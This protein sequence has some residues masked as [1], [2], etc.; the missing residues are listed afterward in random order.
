MD[1]TDH[2]IS[3]YLAAPVRG[4]PG[5]AVDPKEK[6]DNVQAAVQLGYAIRQAFPSLLLFVPHE[7]EVVID[8]LWHN[9]LPSD[10]I[11]TATSQ[12]AA[13]KDFMIVYDGDGISAGMAREIDV[14]SKAG[15]P[16]VCFDLFNEEAKEEIAMVMQKLKG[17]KDETGRSLQI[18]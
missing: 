15:K 13:A 4:K 6:W 18:D 8:R 10:D 16:I 9:G 12:I 3:A 5:D 7:N 17:L 11:I 1:G 2:K 14:V